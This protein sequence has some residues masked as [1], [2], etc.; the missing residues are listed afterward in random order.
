VATVGKLDIRHAA[1]NVIPGEVVCSL[2]LRSADA[3]RLAW[4]S[5]EVKEKVQDIALR[6]NITFEWNVIQQTAPVTCDAGFTT[7]LAQAIA[8]SG[9]EVVPLVSG[10]GHDAVPISK[11]APAT[12]LFV[13]CFQGISHNPLENVELLDLAAALRVS[14]RFL[15]QLITHHS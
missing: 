8:E 6:R 11:V 12:M 5:Q 4:A 1:S 15:T 9:Y 14:E 3:D 13:R 10:A 2:D 7:L